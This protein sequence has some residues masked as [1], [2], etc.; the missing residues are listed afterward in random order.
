MQPSKKVAFDFSNE[1]LIGTYL[2]LPLITFARDKCLP[3]SMALAV[4][5]AGS[6]LSKPHW[7]GRRKGTILAEHLKRQKH[8]WVKI[9]SHFFANG[10]P[11]INIHLTEKL[12]QKHLGRAWT[13]ILNLWSEDLEGLRKS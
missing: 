2:L 13:R 8:Q 11:S 7:F 12:N 5:F 4:F 9:V 1:K 10:S 3:T 6:V